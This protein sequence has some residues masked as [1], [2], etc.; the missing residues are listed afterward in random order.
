MPTMAQIIERNRRHGGAP[1]IILLD[2][3]LPTGKHIRAARDVVSHV[4]PRQDADTQTLAEAG[5]AATYELAAYGE[6]TYSLTGEWAGTVALERADGEAW[7]TVGT[8][9]GRAEDTM[10]GQAAGTYRLVAR[11]GFAGS[12]RA[13]VGGPECLLWQAMN[14]DHEL[15]RE[16]E[17]A[18]AGALVLTIFNAGGVPQQYVE[19]LED[20]R[21]ANG[22]APCNV[23]LLVVNT[24]LLDEAEPVRELQFVDA[25]IAI[26]PPMSHVRISLG[27]PRTFARRVPRGIIMRDYCRWQ[28]EEQCPHVAICR[29]TLAHCKEITETLEAG[30]I[31]YF[32]G[33]PFMGGGALYG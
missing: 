27:V 16:G 17:G 30:R 10:A 33:F 22:R 11:E 2:V 29:H 3:E 32:G 12:C 23:R 7:D 15:W 20:W 26:P 9:T 4:W 31:E 28:R 6:L 5:D 18:R 19:E 14:F 25:G 8:F 21:K 1:Y 13:I 24:A